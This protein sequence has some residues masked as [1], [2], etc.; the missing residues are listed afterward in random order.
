MSKAEQ[1][2]KWMSERMGH[3]PQLQLALE[4]VKELEL[5]LGLVKIALEQKGT[6]LNSCQRALEREQ[7]KHF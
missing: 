2:K 5:D 7:N 4:A 1:F 3:S 6:L